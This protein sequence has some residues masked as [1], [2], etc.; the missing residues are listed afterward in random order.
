MESLFKRTVKVDARCICRFCVE[1]FQ[2]SFV[3]IQEWESRRTP[4]C[5]YSIVGLS[6]NFRVAI[7]FSG[8]LIELKNDGNEELIIL[9]I[10]TQLQRPF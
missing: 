5:I 10:R 8:R 3:S 1:H 4:I 2:F 9:V 6:T 7:T